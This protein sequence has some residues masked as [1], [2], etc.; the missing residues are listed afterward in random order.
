VGGKVGG[1]FLASGLGSQTSIQLID[2]TK[3]NKNPIYIPG[4]DFPPQPNTGKNSK[5]NT[6]TFK[7]KNTGPSNFHSK[8]NST[9]KLDEWDD[10]RSL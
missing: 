3:G 5:N 7:F 10:K 6:K 9:H 4:S 1:P 2:E 8:T